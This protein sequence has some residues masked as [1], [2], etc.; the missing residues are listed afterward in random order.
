MFE[1]EFCANGELLEED[2]ELRC[3]IYGCNTYFCKPAPETS[4]RLTAQYTV[5]EAVHLK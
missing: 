3:H 1:P 4:Q 5:F 2:E